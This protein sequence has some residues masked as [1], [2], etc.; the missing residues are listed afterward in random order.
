MKPLF[1]GWTDSVM[2]CRNGVIQDAFEKGEFG[3]GTVTVPSMPPRQD[4]YGTNAVSFLVLPTCFSPFSEASCIKLHLFVII[5]LFVWNN[6]TKVLRSAMC[7]RRK[8]GVLRP[9]AYYAAESF[10]R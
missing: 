5:A 10:D 7:M 9:V 3:N 6:K 1:E 2:N 8:H 4:L